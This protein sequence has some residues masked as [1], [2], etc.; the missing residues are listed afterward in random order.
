MEFKMFDIKELVKIQMEIDGLDALENI[1]AEEKLVE[2]Y[3]QPG[4][5]KHLYL[6]IIE[7]FFL[8]YFLTAPNKE[9]E[10]KMQQVREEYFKTSC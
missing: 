9:L 2:H 8:K 5:K 10:L 1:G 6:S 4:H 3:S 7:T